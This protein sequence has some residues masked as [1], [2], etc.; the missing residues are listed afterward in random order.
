[1]YNSHFTQKMYPQIQGG[2]LDNRL[3]SDCRGL[4]KKDTLTN[5]SCYNTLHDYFGGKTK[6][7]EVLRVWFTT[8]ED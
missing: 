2:I 8:T 3:N 1:M 5:T 6:I 4:E 7:H